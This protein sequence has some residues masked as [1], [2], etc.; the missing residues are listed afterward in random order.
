MGLLLHEV[1]PQ[2]S[3]HLLKKTQGILNGRGGGVTVSTMVRMEE[4]DKNDE[5]K[6]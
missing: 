6:T 4:G 5:L 2:I 3:D 1:P